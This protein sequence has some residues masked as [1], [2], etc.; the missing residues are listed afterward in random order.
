M[1]ASAV[2]NAVVEL[3][4]EVVLMDNDKTYTRRNTLERCGSDCEKT[5]IIH[6]L[7]RTKGRESDAA[8][9]LGITKSVL[10]DKIR[11]YE[12]DCTEFE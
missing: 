5:V 12:I 3:S 8:D 4:D 11:K 10:A 7:R 1:Y 2:A 9:L 6:V